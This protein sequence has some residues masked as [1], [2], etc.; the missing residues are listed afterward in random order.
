VDYRKFD[1]FV[2]QLSRRLFRRTFVGGALG[3]SVLNTLGLAADVDE[4]SARNNPKKGKNRRANAG[5]KDNDSRKGG[6]PTGSQKRGENKGKAADK[7]KGK[8]KGKSPPCLANG[9]KCPTKSKKS[10][11]KKGKRQGTTKQGCNDCC[12]GFSQNGVCACRP[13]GSSG[14]GSHDECCSG[15]CAN[16]VCRGG[17]FFS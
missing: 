16:S 9:Q 12:S 3:A 8:S 14:C 6:K 13:D 2:R 4:T 1:A 7:R 10:S 15:V 17:A 11:G 5:G